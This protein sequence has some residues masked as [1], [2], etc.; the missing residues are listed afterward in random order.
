MSKQGELSDVL[1]RLRTG[2]VQAREEIIARCERRLREMARA[3]LNDFDRLRRWEETDDVVQNALLRLHRALVDVKPESTRNFYRLAATQIRRQLLDLIRH[4]YGPEGLGT[5]HRSDP[6]VVATISQRVARKVNG[7]LRPN[8]PDQWQHLH[9]AVA[10]LPD[11]EREV[12]DLLWY[13]RLTQEEAGELLDVTA[14]TIK[15]RWRSAKIL[16]REMLHEFS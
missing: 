9:D 4:Y 12:V 1:E 16:L 14:R 13:H 5:N 6:E 8:S 15:R 3:A 10:A 2:D 11:K 7:S